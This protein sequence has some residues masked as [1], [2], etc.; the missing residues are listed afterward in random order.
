VRAVVVDT[1]GTPDVLHIKQLP[2]PE[3]PPGG[4]VVQVLA[5]GVNYADI[6][7]R[8]GLYKKVLTLPRQMGKEAAGVVVA[9]HSDAVEFDVGDPVIV[10]RFANGCYAD[11]VPTEAHEVLRPPRGLSFV[12][13]AAFGTNFATAWWAM[14]EIARVRPGESALIQA[15][16]GGVGTAA[17]MLA[18]TAGCGLIIGTAGGP[19]K[20]ELVRAAGADEVVNYLVDD[21]RPIVARLTHDVGIDYCLESVG[22]DAYAQSLDALAP[23][24]RLV[25]IGFSSIHDDYAHAIRRLHP[26]T[27][28]QRSISVGGLNL[29]NISFQRQRN[30]WNQLVEHAE[31]H[32]L[33]PIVGQVHPFE[34]IREAHDALES[35]RSTGKVVLTLDPQA[36]DVPTPALLARG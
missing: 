13:M 30:V 15:A 4:Y 20:G 23:M 26:L 32:N 3:P 10:V 14:H 34:R 18:R 1:F 24:G 25:I 31:E 11:K 22:G 21:L 8:R 35:R 2:D 7:E 33:R 12:E 5:A 9:R 28:F 27:V 36:L 29:D 6:V 16:A 17:V 19:A